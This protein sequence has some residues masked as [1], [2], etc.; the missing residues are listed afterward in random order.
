M[1]TLA[2]TIG[3][4]DVYLMDTYVYLEHL[5][6]L[7]CLCLCFSWRLYQSLRTNAARLASAS[8]LLQ[9]PVSP[10]Y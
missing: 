4:N 5:D 8:G 2:Y 9:V 7:P 6:D 3:T 1:H 10:C